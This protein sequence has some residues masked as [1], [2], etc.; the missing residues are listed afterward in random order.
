MDPT[1]TSAGV[2]LPLGLVV[3]VG[4]GA[5]FI[6]RYS[7]HEGDS[8][9]PSVTALAMTYVVFRAL[10]SLWPRGDSA[11]TTQ[12]L[13]QTGGI[14]QAIRNGLGMLPNFRIPAPSARVIDGYTVKS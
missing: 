2:T 9:L 4:A 12:T 11:A 5:F 7:K 8:P 13:P 3:T 6:G 14:S 1:Q 10:D